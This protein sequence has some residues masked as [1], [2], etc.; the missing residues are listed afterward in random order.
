MITALANN[1]IE[2]GDL[3]FS[4]FALAVQNAGMDDLRVIADEFQDGVEGY[5]TN[6]FFV[7]KDGADQDRQGS[8]GQGGRDQRRRQR[9][10]H[11]V[12]ARCCA[13]TGSTTA[14]T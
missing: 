13:R 14:R 9:G 6:E 3:A 11:R 2:I 1:E 5:Y 7:L 8:E 12:R 10:R 4:S